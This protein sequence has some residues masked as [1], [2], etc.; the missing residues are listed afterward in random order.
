MKLKMGRQDQALFAR[1]YTKFRCWFSSRHFQNLGVEK[2]GA[3]THSLGLLN[4]KSSTGSGQ[5][6]GE[7][8][9][10]KADHILDSNVLQ[11]GQNNYTKVSDVSLPLI[12]KP[13]GKPGTSNRL[14]SILP[15]SPWINGPSPSTAC[16]PVSTFMIQNS[17]CI[18]SPRRLACPFTYNIIGLIFF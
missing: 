6:K 4:G 15:D 12:R 18:C 7:N 3:D 17:K 16:L 8:D 5:E 2:T 1:T 13:A 11:V 10:S 9:T 14:D